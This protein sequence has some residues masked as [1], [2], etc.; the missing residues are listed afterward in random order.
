MVARPLPQDPLGFGTDHSVDAV[1][2][3]HLRPGEA[4]VWSGRPAPPV[5]SRRQGWL[6]IIGALLA[7]CGIAVG[8][9]GLFHFFL[10]GSVNWLMTAQGLLYV[11]LGGF[12]FFA[13]LGSLL[14]AGWT[15]YAVTDQRAVILRRYL[16]NRVTSFEAGQVEAPQRVDCGDGLVHLVFA[17][18]KKPWL[19]QNK[20]NQHMTP[21][22]FFRIEDADALEASLLKLRGAVVPSEPSD[23]RAVEPV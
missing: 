18:R 16:W 23:H 14:R 12:F 20:T 13:A 2:R 7:A 8:L 22:G 4:L 9:Y 11:F 10:D 1:L 6:G 3:G 21:Q 5:L 17:W 15:V 19:L